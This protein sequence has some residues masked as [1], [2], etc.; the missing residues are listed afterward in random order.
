MQPPQPTE[1]VHHKT[2]I[3]Q[4]FLSKLT[5]EAF[6]S[7]RLGEVRGEVAAGPFL[8][9]APVSAL[10]VMPVVC[11]SVHVRHTAPS[12]N[13]CLTESPLGRNIV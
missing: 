6:E 13:T 8:C 3:L 5:D 7:V 11:D 12:P 1:H 9:C 4:V 2:K 10:A